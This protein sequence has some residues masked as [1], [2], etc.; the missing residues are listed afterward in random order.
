MKSAVS[1]AV[2]AVSV[3]AVLGASAACSS[4]GAGDGGGGGGG[5]RNPAKRHASASTLERAA[6]TA[7]DIKGYDVEDPNASGESGRSGG[8][9]GS[10]ESGAGAAAPPAGKPSA[11]ECGPLAAALGAGAAPGRTK[12]HVGRVLTPA[13]GKEL[14]TT[15]VDLSGRTKAGAE[16]A[17]ADLRAASKS[18][19][20]TAF[21]IGDDRYVG[22]EPLPAPDKGDEAVSYKAAHRKGDYVTRESVTVVR[23]GSTLVVFDASNLYDPESVQNDREAAKDGTEGIR[24]PTADEDPTVAPKIIDAQLAK[25][26][27]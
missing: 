12:A 22:L 18:K 23:S 3:A 1:R 15:G 21:R 26:T 17:M 10:G 25:L 20:C 16:H 14:T 4:S 6:L 11:A 13:D 7:G 24:S 19:K 5:D 9:G 27:T 8:S 2:V